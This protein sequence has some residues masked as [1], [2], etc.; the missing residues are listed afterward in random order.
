MNGYFFFSLLIMVCKG[1]FNMHLTITLLLFAAA[2][3]AVPSNL[4]RDDSKFTCFDMPTALAGPSDFITGLDG[5][6]WVEDLLVDKV[7]RIDVNTG[8]SQSMIYYLRMVLSLQS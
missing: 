2:V 1:I 4:A 5:A 8:E 3:F 7:A 6:I